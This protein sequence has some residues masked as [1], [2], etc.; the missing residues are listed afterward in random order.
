MRSL[1]I[2]LLGG[3][4]VSMAIYPL[5]SLYVPDLPFTFIVLTGVFW[6]AA[7]RLALMAADRHEIAQNGRFGGVV[8]FAYRWW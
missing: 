8:R 6:W 3:Y 7:G 5:A 4:L 1:L 2:T